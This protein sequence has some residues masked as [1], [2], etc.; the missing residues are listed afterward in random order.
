MRLARKCVRKLTLHTSGS[1]ADV[2]Y[3][4][5]Q[6]LS[7]PLVGRVGLQVAHGL[8]WIHEQGILHRDIRSAN[9]LVDNEFSACI[10]DFGLS[11]S[12]VRPPPAC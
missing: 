1:L 10:A 4:D 2:I 7:H 12:V 11:L 3:R 9:V 8:R 5:K 6:Q